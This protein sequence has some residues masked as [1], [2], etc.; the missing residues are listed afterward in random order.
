MQTP[1][2]GNTADLLAPVPAVQGAL[3]GY[4]RV[5]TQGHL[6]DRQVHA[7][8][9]AGCIRIF[10]DKKS[11]KNAKREELRKA[12]DYLREGDTLVVPSL[13]RLGRSIQDLIAIVSGLRKRGIGF[14]SLHEA[15]DTTTSGGRLVFHVFAALAEFIR[16][17]IVQGTNEGLDAARARGARLGR[18]PAMTEEQIRHARD[19]LT[20]PENTVT[21]I[22]KLL[23]VSRNTIYKYVPELKGDRATLGEPDSTPALPRPAQSAE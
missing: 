23:G 12:L 13:D 14:T 20:R 17:L 6:L 5:S 9:E 2:D 11:G 15:L 21:S 8:T 16:E 22:A 10:A 18:P 19:L 3:V 1:S 7:L 4:A